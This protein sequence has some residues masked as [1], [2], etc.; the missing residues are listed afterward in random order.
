MPVPVPRHTRGPAHPINKLNIHPGDASHHL[1]VFHNLTQSLPLPPPGP[2][3]SFGTREEWISSLPSWRRNKPRRIWEEDDTQVYDARNVQS[4]Q[5]GLNNADNASFIKGDRAQACIPPVLTLIGHAGQAN[6]PKNTTQEGEGDA[7]DEMSSTSLEYDAESQWSGHSLFTRDG[8]AMEV[9]PGY[10]DGPYATSQDHTLSQFYDLAPERQDVYDNGVYTPVSDNMSPGRLVDGDPQSSPLGP[11]TPF[12]EF[13][14]RAVETALIHGNDSATFPPGP[15]DLRHVGPTR[16]AVYGIAHFDRSRHY[17]PVEQHRRQ[18]VVVATGPEPVPSV[19]LSYKKV[20]D[21]LAEWVASYVW[22]ACT[23]GMSLPPEYAGS[24]YEITASVAIVTPN[25]YVFRS[26][27]ASNQYS[28]M[29][30]SY[31]ANSIRSLFMSTL[32]QPS[33]IFLAVWYIVRLPVRFGHVQFG[34]DHVKEIRFRAELLGLDELQHEGMDRETME[35]H[36]P[37]RLVLLG[38]M[39]ANKWLD[40]HTFSNKTWHTV[41][42]VPIQS[43]NRL[44]SL[45]LDIF[46]YDLSVPSYAWAQWLD[47]VMSYHVSLSSPSHPQPISRP[48]SN[49]H[50]IV[51]KTIEELVDIA[52]ASKV[53]RHCGDPSCSKAHPEPVFIGLEQR[54]RERLDASVAFEDSAVDVLEIDLDQDGPLREEYM[55][56]RR[57]SRANSLRESVKNAAGVTHTDKDR[58]WERAIGMERN[59]PPPAKWSPA[60]DEPLVRDGSRNPGHYVA[61]RPP[62]QPQHAQLLPPIQF[63]Q[64]L[65]PPTEY[66]Q[67]GWNAGTAFGPARL[68]IQ[69]P[70]PYSTP[71]GPLLHSRSASL[72]A[73]HACAIPDYPHSRSQS[74]THFE[75][76]CSDMR[77]TSQKMV[78][79]PPPEL[80]WT[81]AEQYGYGATYGRFFDPGAYYEAHWVRT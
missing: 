22:K 3:P 27:G 6:M 52:V 48:S 8:E 25:T 61:V 63:Y 13:V 33:A 5:Q 66:Q 4:F 32:L 70:G 40:D 74:Q 17:D 50:S 56:K 34:P 39:L 65:P 77:M 73:G 24:T 78:P 68:G 35:I 21:P 23:N 37:F 41:S 43:L 60:A 57:V 71:Y 30:P 15:F 31:L 16:E 36:A 67:Q 81:G 2:P 29:P 18:D 10:G 19:T 54:I 11:M 12:G 42:A 38:C 44:E 69:H 58:D 72:S 49:P 59:L 9:E 26:A 7:D 51:R 20:A 55:P 53:F 46:A 62:M 64:A 28:T 47:H 79:L 75:Y 76:A 45:A 1:S 14:D 80:P